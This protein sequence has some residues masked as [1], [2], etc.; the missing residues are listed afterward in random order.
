MLKINFFDILLKSVIQAKWLILIAIVVLVIKAYLNS[1]KGKG[2]LAEVVAKSKL[3]LMLDSSIYTVY[4]D[5]IVPDKFGSTQIDIL[6]L[7][8]Y[9]IFVIEVK[10]YGGWIFAD[11]KSEF[12]MQN[13]YGKKNRFQNPIRQNYRHTM[14]LSEYL[15]LPISKFHPLVMFIGEAVFKTPI[16]RGVLTSGGTT[17]IKSFSERVFTDVEI[18]SIKTSL[19]RLKNNKKQLQ[20]PFLEQIKKR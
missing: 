16:P 6:V 18:A 9:G 3:N 10:N 1:R 19:D 8:P 14:A 5:L 11:E 4:Y 12:W 17:Y 20:K 7:S 15:R 13:Y 2:K